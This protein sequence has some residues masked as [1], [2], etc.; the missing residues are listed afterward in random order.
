M[1][2]L[3]DIFPVPGTVA[4]YAFWLGAFRVMVDQLLAG[5]EGGDIAARFTLSEF[6][7][8]NKS[9]IGDWADVWYTTRPPK[10][11]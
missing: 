4:W 3:D 2:E 8:Q 11:G 6:D 1:D 10:G 9:I 7:R 5:T